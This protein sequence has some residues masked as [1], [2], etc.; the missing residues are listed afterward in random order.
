MIVVSI[1]QFYPNS[2]STQHNANS[3]DQKNEN[4]RKNPID[5]LQLNRLIPDW[6]YAYQEMRQSKEIQ[7]SRAKGVH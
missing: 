6:V 4:Y 7:A 3:K 2:P 5:A 1:F